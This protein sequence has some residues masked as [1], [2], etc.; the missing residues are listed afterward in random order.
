LFFF[1]ETQYRRDQAAEPEQ[2]DVPS[3]EKEPA[4]VTETFPTMP[5]SYRTFRLGVWSGINPGIKKDTT[6]LNLFLRPWPLVFYPAVMYSFITFSIN[7]GCI[8]AVANTVAIVFQSAPYNMSPGIQSV[9]YYVNMIF[10]ISIGAFCGGALSDR[11]IQWRAR[12]NNGV[13]EPEVRLELL[14]LPLFIVPAG[15]LMYNSAAIL[16]ISVGMEKA[17]SILA[18]GRCH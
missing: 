17:Q 2:S 9:A 3:T 16:L 18:H 13:F 12:K 4:T 14:I 15:A 6:L 8:L 7:I 5:N 10:G 1:P 11:Y